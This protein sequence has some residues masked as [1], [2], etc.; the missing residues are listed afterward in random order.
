MPNIYYK[1]TDKDM[2]CRGV[3][4]VL[5]EWSTP[6]E[7]E[8]EMCENGYHFCTVPSGVWTYYKQGDT[9][10]FEIEV[11]DAIL[12]TDAGASAKSICR[13]VKLVKEI[14]P[15]KESGSNTGDCNTGNNNT[16]DWNTGYSNIGNWN[17]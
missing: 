3:Q 2:K 6:I 8:L 9:R 5:G 1:A 17:T 7:G 13:R 10:V 15:A 16:G 14:T 12:S 11:E 4:F